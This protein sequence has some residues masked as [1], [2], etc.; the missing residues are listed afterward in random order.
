MKED[1]E[2][3]E[4]R[5]MCVCAPALCCCGGHLPGERPFSNSL[6][7]FLCV[8]STKQSAHE[9]FLRKKLLFLYYPSHLKEQNQEVF[10]VIHQDPIRRFQPTLHSSASSSSSCFSPDTFSSGIYT[11]RGRANKPSISLIE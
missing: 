7:L 11:V 9:S 4:K 5:G 6:S 10:L 3:E 8:S 2:G 1:E